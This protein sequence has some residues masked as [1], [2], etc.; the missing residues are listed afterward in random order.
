V[1][2]GGSR[3]V[4]GD[5]QAVFAGTAGARLACG[6]MK[7]MTNSMP[8]AVL[9]GLCNVRGS[10]KHLCALGGRGGAWKQRRLAGSRAP[11]VRRR[12]CPILRVREHCHHFCQELRW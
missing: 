8:I 9:S 2:A 11:F 12:Q 10:F 6:K 4:R 1:G 3:A 5:S 7:T